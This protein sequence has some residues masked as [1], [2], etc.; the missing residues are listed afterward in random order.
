MGDE[1][2]RMPWGCVPHA[3]PKAE[4][5]ANKGRSGRAEA[6]RCKSAG[7]AYPGSNPGAATWK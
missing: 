4:G 7:S 3:F 2:Q 1:F 6:A 5:L